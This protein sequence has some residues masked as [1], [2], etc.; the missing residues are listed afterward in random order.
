MRLANPLKI[1]VVEKFTQQKLL[2]HKGKT[3]ENGLY[4]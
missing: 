3:S 4:Q 2:Y 1:F